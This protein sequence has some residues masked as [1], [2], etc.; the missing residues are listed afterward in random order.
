MEKESF[1]KKLEKHHQ[2]GKPLVS[3]FQ[4]DVLNFFDKHGREFLWRTTRNPYEILVSEVML[5]QTQTER[6]AKRYPP[7]LAQFPTCESLAH[8]S[9]P[10]VLRAWEGLGYY[11]RARNLFAAANVIVETH[12]SSVPQSVEQLVELPGIGE[13]TA[14][15]IAT[16]AYGARVPFIETNIRTVFLHFFCRNKANVT[17]CQLLQL[18]E[19]TMYTKDSRRWFYALMDLG[20]AIKQLRGNP[21]A[22]SKHHRPQSAFSGSKR[23]ARAQILRYVLKTPGRREAEIK[24][25]VHINEKFFDAALQELV[26]EGFLVRSSRGIYKVKG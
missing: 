17:D 14:R 18:I 11:R 16:F 9:L 12:K 20:V 22:Q 23:E 3:R 4:K 24:K 6:V 2:V 7:F 10:E 5:Q 13:Y 15:A 25:E 26:L 8:A 21:N 19:E 1:L